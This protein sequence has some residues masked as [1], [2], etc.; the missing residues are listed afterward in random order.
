[1]SVV[2]YECGLFYYI[3]S[4]MVL[5]LCCH[6]GVPSYLLCITMYGVLLVLYWEVCVRLSFFFF[7]CVYVCINLLAYVMRQV[8]VV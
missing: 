3:I 5:L 7:V 1:M 6:C 4:L 8:E 2:C